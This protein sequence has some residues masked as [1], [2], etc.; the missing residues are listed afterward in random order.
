[1]KN[2]A[3]LA[4]ENTSLSALALPTDIF[5]AAGVFWNRIFDEEADPRFSV[6]IATKD[7][8]PV[9]CLHTV[10]ITPDC[11]MQDLDDIDLLIVSPVS[12]MSNSLLKYRASM[13]FI[14]QA[15]D[16]GTHVASICTG[17]F[18]LA[19]TGLLDGKKA[20]THWGLAHHF[21]KRFPKALLEPQKTVTED[22]NLF[23]SGGAN[24]GADLSLH[25]VRKYCGNQI[26]YRCARAL[27]LDPARVTQAPYETFFFN[28]RHGDKQITVIQKWIESHYHEDLQVESMTRKAGMSRRTFERRF[29]NATGYSP[30][31]YL[32]HVRVES[33]KL[34]L[35]AGA[36]TFEQITCRVGYEDTSSFRRIFQKTTGLSP[37]SYREKFK[38]IPTPKRQSDRYG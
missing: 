24:A 33:A 12:D 30:C 25:L 35:E 2:V 14:C 27:V 19:E 32:Q 7:G 16:A 4:Y 5:H 38:A 28:K 29:K 26:G 20:T 18:L 17:A 11:A 13:D 3:I 15:Y 8:Q 1:M 22:S 9:R 31:S 34:M 37:S 36:D 10:S 21:A 6:R 23:C